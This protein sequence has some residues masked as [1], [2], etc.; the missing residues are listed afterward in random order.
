M[1]DLYYTIAFQENCFVSGL[2]VRIK[3]PQGI[4]K[5]KIDEIE[6]ALQSKLEEVEGGE[7]NTEDIVYEVLDALEIPYRTPVP[8]YTIYL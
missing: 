4:T 6:D 2:D 8:D 7:F 5:E 3:I 1:E